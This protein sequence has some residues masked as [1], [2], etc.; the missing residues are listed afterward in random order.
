M[1][2]R[3]IVLIGAL[4]L[5]A[6][7]PP[8][9]AGD[10]STRDAGALDSGALDAS[11]P[12]DASPADAG[13]R[14][15][16]VDGSSRDASLPDAAMLDAGVRD[17][18]SAGD[19][20]ADASVNVDGGARDSGV[21]DAGG[22][23]AGGADA[24]APDSGAQ[25]AGLD[26]G[27]SGGACISGA[28]GT[29]AVRFRWDGSGPGS[30]AYVVYEENQLPDTSRW[31]VSAAA[32]SFDYTP[33]YDDTF[34]GEGGL[35]LEGTAFIDVELST[36]GLSSLS[37]VTVAIYGRSFATTT[38]GSFTWQTFDGTGASPYGSIANSTPYEWY[39]ADATTEFSPGDG[40]VLLRLRAGPPS[41]ALIV[42]RVEI[43]FDAG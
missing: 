33:V 6:C 37:N 4:A 20:S 24:G 32:M 23:D 10:A 31:H 1:R 7:A 21:H 19:A 9:D 2:S 30:T 26:A 34:L 22:A 8:V 25:D 29:H 16:R 41:D 14:D 18:G 11:A 39:T 35:D 13:A 28:I 42:H 27:T 40:S 38:S 43:C 3:C 12:A 17:A 5:A 36:I 15:A